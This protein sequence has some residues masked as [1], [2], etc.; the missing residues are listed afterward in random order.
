MHSE[1]FEKFYQNTIG[2]EQIISTPKGDKKMIYADWIASGRLYE[3]IEKIMREKVAPYCANTHTETSTTGTLM[4][5]AYKEAKEFI[6]KEVNANQKDILIFSGSGMTASINKLQ[7][8][9]GL[10]VP[11]NIKKYLLNTQYISTNHKPIVFV[12]H[13]EHHSNHTS[14][15]ETIADVEIINPN[16]DGTVNLEHFAELLNQYKERKFKIASVSACSNVTGIFTPYYEIA[17]MIHK[18]GGVCFV[19]FACSAPYV[20]INMHP[21]NPLQQLDVVF[22]S[23]HKFLG[24]PGTPGIMILNSDLYENT[25]PDNSGGGTVKFTSPWKFHS[26]ID[27]IEEREDGGTPPFLQGIKAALCFK[28]KKEMDT[29]K[30]LEREKEMVVKVIDELSKI[31]N[32]YVLEP[33]IKDRIGAISFYIDGLHYNLGVK[34]LNDY[35]GIQVRGGGACAGTYGHYLL[36]IDKEKS[37][38]IYIQIEKGDYFIRPG[39]IRLSLHPTLS[40]Q[41]IDYIIDAIK[42]IAANH[43]EL[44]QSYIYTSHNN[45]FSY[46]DDKQNFEND[47]VDILFH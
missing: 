2:I 28:L 40:N 44:S 45:S 29:N 35:F 23:P 25:I 15:L 32:L 36:H 7:R 12:T 30:M 26:Y 16:E 1:H 39:W 19:D 3:P 47:F 6:K 4:T 21:E 22:I 31:K 8:I 13:L 27:N 34:L 41:N 33:Q 9:L 10:R 20:E 43:H 24:G 37:S 14:W 42:Y 17:E 38:S 11:E 46:I 5:K 18:E